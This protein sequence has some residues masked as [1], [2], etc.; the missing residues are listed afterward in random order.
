MIHN[1]A[2]L[3]DSNVAPELLRPVSSLQALKGTLTDPEIALGKLRT[4]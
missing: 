3:L 1:V 4:L 2:C